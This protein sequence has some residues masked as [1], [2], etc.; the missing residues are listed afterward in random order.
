MIRKFTVTCLLLLLYIGA[1]LQLPQKQ[2]TCRIAFYNTENFFDT[3]DDSLTADEEFTPDGARHWTSKRYHT[4]LENTYKTILAMGTL[5]PPHVVG[6]CEI[7]NKK[8]L[9]DLV[10]HTPLAKFGYRIIHSDSPDKRGIDV[11]VIYD[12]SRATLLK[13]RYNPVK[14]PGL[15]T[16]QILYCKFL[17]EGDTLHIFVNHWPSRSAGQL[18]TEDYREAAATKLKSLTDSIFRLK[19]NSRIII[20][21]DLNDTPG[22]KSITKV[23][24]VS[25]PPKEP[26]SGKLYNMSQASEHGNFNG[27][28]KYKSEWAIFD[29][30]I[31]SGN[32]LKKHKGLYTFPG[33]YHIFGEPYLLEKDEKYNGYKPNRTYNGYKYHGGYSDHLP[34]YLDLLIY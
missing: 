4:K 29:Q 12:P 24:G 20:M 9:L 17:M 23:L 1:G 10:N 30:F 18:N 28:V 34:V 19:V 15:H 7:E 8:V 3:K 33:G 31:V 22:D 25:Q 6:L 11:A 14:Y 13:S 21:G 5:N 32:M 2:K 26:A 16:R 27:T